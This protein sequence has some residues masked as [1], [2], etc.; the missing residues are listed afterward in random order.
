M[1]IRFGNG[2]WY[3][4][5]PLIANHLSHPVNIGLSF[6]QAVDANLLIK[7]CVLLFPSFQIQLPGWWAG[8]REVPAEPLRQ[9]TIE[10]MT[11]MAVEEVKH[12]KWMLPEEWCFHNFPCDVIITCHYC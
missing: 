11:R 10:K 7:Y 3:N 6:L 12:L 1:G 5:E 4:V 9:L 2:P 8:R